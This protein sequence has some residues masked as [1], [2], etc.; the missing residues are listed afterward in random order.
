MAGLGPELAT[1]L[2]GDWTSEADVTELGT[3]ATVFPLVTNGRANETVTL[4]TLLRPAPA[5]VVGV[6]ILVMVAVNKRGYSM[7]NMFTV[8]HVCVTVPCQGTYRAC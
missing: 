3:M 6:D 4:L 7:F 1:T 8:V 2:D 5:L